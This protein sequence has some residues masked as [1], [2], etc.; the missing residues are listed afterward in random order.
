MTYPNPINVQAFLD[1]DI[2][3][4]D[5]TALIIDE[6][7]V[8]TAK[9]ITREAMVCCGQDWFNAVFKALNADIQVEWHVHEGQWLEANT[10]LCTLKGNARSLLTGE[11]TALNLLQ[12]LSAISTQARIYAN[13]VAGTGCKVLDTR[14]T[15]PGLR[16]AQKYAVAC[17]GCHN[18]RVGLY[19]GILIKENHIIAAGSI[20]QAVAQARKM[21]NILLEVEVESMSELDQALAAQPD[22]IMLDN[23]SVS[24][25]QVA[26]KK[27][28]GRCALEASGNI[29]LSNI[30]EIA[31]T[32]VD[33]IS[34]GALTKNVQ[35][36]DLSMRIDL[37]DE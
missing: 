24:Q 13:R 28:A 5:I 36:V 1:E 2:G 4:G 10:L 23:F 32:G 12:T 11:R 34:I 3:S 15:I 37:E 18:H 7:R 31:E 33:Y 26:V 25:L 19:D 16:D 35:A 21:S 30:R 14:K 20:A 8:A 22:R 9:V 17:G 27:V 29:L 6:A